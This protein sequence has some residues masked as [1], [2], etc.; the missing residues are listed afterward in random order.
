MALKATDVAPAR[1]VTVA[2][3]VMPPLFDDSVTANPPVGAGPFRFTI[4]VV[5]APPRTVA[6]ESVT[7]VTERG[8][9][10]SVAVTVV[11]P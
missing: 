4:P 2:G 5:E 11:V 3:T 1:T 9:K 8:I 10:V 6:G 7:L